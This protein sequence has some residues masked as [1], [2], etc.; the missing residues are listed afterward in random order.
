[1]YIDALPEVLQTLQLA[2]WL[3]GLILATCLLAG[4]RQ[5]RLMFFSGLVVLLGTA[6]SSFWAALQQ[7]PLRAYKLFCVFFLGLPLFYFLAWRATRHKAQ[8]GIFWL[9]LGLPWGVG[10]LLGLNVAASLLDAH[11]SAH[12]KQLRGQSIGAYLAVFVPACME[13]AFTV[14][15]VAGLFFLGTRSALYR[16]AGETPPDRRENTPGLVASFWLGLGL[17]FLSGSGWNIISARTGAVAACLVF[18]LGLC[19]LFSLWRVNGFHRI[20][21]LLWAS[22]ALAAFSLY[23]ADKL[24]PVFFP[25]SK[26]VAFMNGRPGLVLAGCLFAAALL[27]MGRKPLF[28]GKLS[29]SPPAETA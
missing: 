12:V 2:K 18:V 26:L 25:F 23:L 9:R 11:F 6:G 22:L 17:F 28:R 20:F 8:H 27:V 5:A 7:D 13:A 16:K 19:A 1:M 10:M 24:L 21:S 15:V 14:L 4:F 3:I 29:V